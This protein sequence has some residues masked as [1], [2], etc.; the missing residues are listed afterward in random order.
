MVR[1]NH[2]LTV[3]SRRLAALT[4]FV[5]VLAAAVSASSAQAARGMLVGLYD[6][7]Q[8]V[9][10]PDTTFPTL[11]NLRVQ[12]I[13]LDLNWNSIAKR[14]PAVATDPSDPAYDWDGYDGTVLN[15][16]KNKIQVLFT[17]YG[18]PAWAQGKKKGVN[19]APAKM[20]DLRNFA[21]AAARRYSGTFMRDDGTALPAVRKWLAW[22]EP[23]NPLFLSPQW[24]KS[25]KRFIP[26]AAR[27]YVGMCTA[28]WTGEIGRA[29]V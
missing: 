24:V 18:T 7:V 21:T 28:I 23:N 15:A 2:D 8:P 3:A 26:V 5:L 29:H 12:I 9:V 22:N 16:T 20:A 13:R 10:A 1:S 4:A 11:V 17:I 6:P 19:R 27:T 14:R 25:G